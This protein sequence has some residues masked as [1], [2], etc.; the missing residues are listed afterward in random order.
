MVRVIERETSRR[1]CPTGNIL[2]CYPDWTHQEGIPNDTINKQDMFFILSLGQ[3]PD[4]ST[5]R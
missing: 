5:L 4:S 1:K 3:P 2:I